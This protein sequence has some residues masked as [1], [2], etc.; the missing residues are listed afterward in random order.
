V[1]ANVQ[2]GCTLIERTLYR[3]I[4]LGYADEASQH[5]THTALSGVKVSVHGVESLSAP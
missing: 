2:V 4:A 5:L 3:D 1:R